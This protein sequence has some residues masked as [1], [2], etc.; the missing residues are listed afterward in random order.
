MPRSVDYKTRLYSPCGQSVSIDFNFSYHNRSRAYS[1][2]LFSTC[3]Y[4][5]RRGADCRP[6]EPLEFQE[7]GKKTLFRMVLEDCGCA[8]PAAL[9]WLAC[10]PGQRSAAPRGLTAGCPSN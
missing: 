3:E 1:V 4:R 9:L 2:E 5:L 10:L 8:V 7:D 6:E